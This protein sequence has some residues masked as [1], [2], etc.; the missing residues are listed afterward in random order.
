MQSRIGARYNTNAVHWIGGYVQGERTTAASLVYA[1]FGLDQNSYN[2]TDHFVESSPG[3]GQELKLN[4]GN[5]HGYQIKGGIS[6]NL[7]REWQVFGNAGYISKVPICDDVNGKVIDNFKNEKF[8]SF[9]AGA[10]YRAL[11][12][13]LSFDLSLYDTTWRDHSYTFYIANEDLYAQ[14]L[15][16]DERHLGLELQGAYQPVDFL[17]FDAAVSLGNWN[18]LEGRQRT[19]RDG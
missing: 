12:R 9:E 13:G 10:S 15:G 18:Y 11:N 19:S 17:R 3:S 4:S 1:M 14:I 7:T 2:Y 16:V 6:R 8:L 5:L